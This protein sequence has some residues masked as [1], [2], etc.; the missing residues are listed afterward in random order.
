MKTEIV[1]K[2]KCTV[3]G[4]EVTDIGPLDV[5]YHV[6]CV[7]AAWDRALRPPP[8]HCTELVPVPTARSPKSA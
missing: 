6:E 8:A 3:C 5:P 7:M 4:K 2:P 1:A